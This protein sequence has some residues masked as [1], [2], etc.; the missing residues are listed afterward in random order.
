MEYLEADKSDKDHPHPAE[1]PKALYRDE[2]LSDIIDH[3]LQSMDKNK[4]GYVDYTEYRTSESG[5]VII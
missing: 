4:D 2:E 3:L 5:H 1:P